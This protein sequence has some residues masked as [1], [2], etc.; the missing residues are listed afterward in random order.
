MAFTFTPDEK[1]EWP[2]TVCTPKDGEHVEETFKGLFQSVPEGEFYAAPETVPPTASANIDFEIKR[3]MMVFKGWPAG[4][5]LDPT[6]KEVKATEANIRAFLG[7]RPNRLG[8]T[9][10]YPAAITPMDGH[11]AKN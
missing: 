9:D 8:V 7:H 6:G 10:A 3:L 1:F 5:I 11:R 4:E 2:V